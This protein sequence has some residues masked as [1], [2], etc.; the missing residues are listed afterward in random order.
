[1]VQLLSA[2]LHEG[3]CE[4]IALAVEV[5]AVWILLDERE[6]RSTAQRMQMPITGVLG[7]LLRAK[8]QGQIASL[9]QEMERLRKIAHFFI[10]PELERNVLRLAGE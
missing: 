3:E 6:V 4:A 10:S 2:S 8:R 1:M 7:V 9:S 5:K